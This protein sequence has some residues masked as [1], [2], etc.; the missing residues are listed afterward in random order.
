MLLMPNMKVERVAQL[1]PGELFLFEFQDEKYVG[2]LCDF[3]EGRPDHKQ[4][5]LPL[6]PKFSGH[7]DGPR[8]V[9]LP[10]TGVSFGKDFAIRLPIGP[11]GWSADA[12]PNECL[13]LLVIGTDIYFRANGAVMERQ[14]MACYVDVKTGAVAGIPDPPAGRYARPAGTRAYATS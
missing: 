11:E 6:G 3:L 5:I 2:L 13:C 9:E 12:P 1:Q 14:F 10:V 4:L 7:L 8:L